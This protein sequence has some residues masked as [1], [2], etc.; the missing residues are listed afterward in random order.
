MRN[1]RH[2][3]SRNVSATI[4]SIVV[5]L[6][7]FALVAPTSAPAFSGLCGDADGNG[8]VS[9]IDSL[10]ALRGS[11]GLPSPCAHNCD[12]DVDSDRE[13][14]TSDALG[15]LQGAVSEGPYACGFAD[16]CFHD[17][18]C[19][20]GFECGTDPEWYCDAACVPE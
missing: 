14:T 16:Y 17:E 12:C 2:R 7:L 20:D 19:E 5:S 15:I 10:A 13:M 6:G 11:V 3:D 18:D 9:T 4:R 1:N 8:T